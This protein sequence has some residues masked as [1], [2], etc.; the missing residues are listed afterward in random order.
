M[1]SQIQ[2]NYETL[3][4]FSNPVTAGQIPKLTGYICNEPLLLQ[5][6]YLEQLSAA[7]IPSFSGATA[8]QLP[9]F[10][11]DASVFSHRC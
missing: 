5:P 7:G 9:M 10:W 6:S 2:V 4:T 11:K 8:P 1:R 3:V